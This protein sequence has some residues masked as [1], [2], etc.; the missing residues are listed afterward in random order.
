MEK[1]TLGAVETRFADI[2]WDNAPLTTNELIALC[3]KELN[4]KRTTTYTVLKRLS[5][6]GIF[7]KDGKLVSV[8]IPRDRFYSMQSEN[9][10]DRAFNAEKAHGGCQVFDR[11]FNGS[12]PKFLAAFTSERRL[13]REEAEELK[14]LIDSASED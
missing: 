6:R 8:K 9:Y 5:N 10:V 12:L 7:Q 1:Y 11:A 13:S 4:W 14:R 3:E 2:I